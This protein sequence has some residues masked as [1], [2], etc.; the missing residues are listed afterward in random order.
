MQW[1]AMFHELV[2]A[3]FMLVIKLYYRL[4]CLDYHLDNFRYP[5]TG[6]DANMTISTPFTRK[7]IF[8]SDI[9]LFY[10]LVHFDKM[11]LTDNQNPFGIIPQLNSILGKDYLLFFIFFFSSKSLKLKNE[12]VNLAYIRKLNIWTV[13]VGCD[14][15]FLFP[16]LSSSGARDQSQTQTWS[17]TMFTEAREHFFMRLS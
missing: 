10:F 17:P 8:L 13:S 3:E 14:V 15:K 6:L 12:I 5:P 4:Q 16:D 7:N 9:C 2:I 1:C 11:G